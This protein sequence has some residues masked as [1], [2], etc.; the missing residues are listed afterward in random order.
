M[1][2]H[3]ATCASN[4]KKLVHITC[5]I[6]AERNIPLNTACAGGDV[7]DVINAACQS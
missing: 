3:I 5:T 7:C 6:V 2:V 1:Y 4:V